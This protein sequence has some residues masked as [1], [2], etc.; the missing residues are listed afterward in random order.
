MEV[1]RRKRMNCNDAIERLPW[2][3]NGTLDPEERRQ[4]ME[5]VT[6]CP[7][8]K[9][10]LADTRE[11]WHLFAQ[12]APAADLIA[13]AA[14]ETPGGI[15]RELL[16]EHLASCPQCAADLELVRTSRGLA[17]DDGVALLIP[18]PQPAARPVTAAPAGHLRRW[19]SSALAASL[20]GIAFL[21]L[22]LHSAG[23]VGSLK[24]QLTAERQARTQAEQAEQESSL[25]TP[26]A[27]ST[28][29]PGI[30]PNTGMESLPLDAE[31]GDELTLAVDQGVSVMISADDSRF[32]R[33]PGP[34]Y[35]IDV[36]AGGKLV[37]RVP[38]VKLHPADG[39]YTVTF[40][41]GV[42][43]PGE[44]YTLQVYAVQEGKR[45]P[46]ERLVFRAV[47]QPEQGAEPAQ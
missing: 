43:H 34:V 7:A 9:A 26:A 20:A 8:C 22:W 12:H 16:E 42:L 31:R 41:P 19:R 27:P 15:D 44:T 28:T 40:L 29:T 33:L 11:A 5:H 39:S 46:R 30:I 13:Y 35:E 37:A 3:L 32:T 47:T 45:E 18:R 2:L 6:G 25:A 10:A 24:S 17:E 14:G 21:G 36:L 23:Q 1:E 38:G 4:V